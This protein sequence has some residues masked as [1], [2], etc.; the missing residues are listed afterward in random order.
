MMDHNR[1]R[2]K[3]DHWMVCQ[4]NIVQYLTKVWKLDFTPEEVNHMTGLIEV[5]A[6]EVKLGN[7][8][9][10][11]PGGVGRGVL[12]LLAMLSHNCISNSR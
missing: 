6:F 12:P 1:E 3:G 4:H 11:Q 5:N 10:G 7:L 2:M 8:D 9:R